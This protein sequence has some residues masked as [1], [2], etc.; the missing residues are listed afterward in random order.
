MISTSLLMVFWKMLPLPSM[1]IDLSHEGFSPKTF[2]QI[3]KG[4]SAE[5]DVSAVLSV[6]LKFL[7]ALIF[8]CT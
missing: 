7:S 8:L 1:T 4:E 6:Q 5:T 3:L 2:L